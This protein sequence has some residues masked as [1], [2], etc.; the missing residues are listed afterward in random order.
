MYSDDTRVSLDKIAQGHYWAEEYISRLG[1]PR[2]IVRSY[3]IKQISINNF[4][5]IKGVVL[6]SLLPGAF[7][8]HNP[9]WE[10]RKNL[11]CGLISE[12]EALETAKELLVEPKAKAL[13][14]E[15]WDKSILQIRTADA[16]ERFVASIT[17]PLFIPVEKGLFLCLEPGKFPTLTESADSAASRI[18][19]PFFATSTETVVFK[20]RRYINKFLGH[21]ARN[22]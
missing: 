16:A 3:E 17:C 5:E 22:S 15:E 4:V 2:E 14:P 9:L 7:D 12:K 8:Y 19:L 1:K 20:Y 13:P 11:R 21:A 18:P 6:S 10:L